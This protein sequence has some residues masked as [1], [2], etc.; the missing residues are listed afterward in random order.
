MGDVLLF[1][2]KAELTAEQNLAAF[3]QFCREELILFGKDLPFDGD[4]W[5]ITETYPVE[6]SRKRNRVIFSNYDAA[7]ARD[8]IPA[9]APQFIGF[10]KA[11]FRYSLSLRSSTTWANRIAALRVLEHALQAQGLNGMVSHATHETFARACGFIKDGYAAST[12][13]KI[14]G[15]LEEIGKLLVKMNFCQMTPWKNP[16]KRTQDEN[17]RV[18][19]LA[20]KARDDKLP[21]REVIEAVAHVFRSPNSPAERIVT[22]TVA[23]MYC[24]PQRINEVVRLPFD[25]EVDY[26]QENCPHYGLRVPGSK[27]FQDSVR[28][29]LPTMEKVA[30][31]AIS[32]LKDASKE[33]REVA[34][35][36]ET[37]PG[38]IYLLPECEYLRR[39]KFVDQVEVGLMLYGVPRP[40]KSFCANEKIKQAVKGFYLFTDIE[41][42][43]LAKLPSDLCDPRNEA[44]YS[45]S[46]FICRR[47]ELDETLT[48]Y[49]CI[50][51]RISSGEITARLTDSG[52]ANSI[53][54]RR[55]FLERDGT[56]M[57]MRSH[58]VRHYLNT[59]AQ[60]NGV[61]QLDIAM[62]SG[63]A[64]VSQNS[65]Y[66]HVTPAEI[67]NKTKE[68]AVAAG[69]QLFAGPTQIPKIRVVA[70]RD[71]ATGRLITGTAHATLYGMCRHDFAA[72]PCPIHRDCLNCHEHICVKGAQVKLTNIKR[73]HDETAGLLASAEEAERGS[74]HG[75]SRWVEH[76]KRTLEHC[77][78]LIA[79]LESSTIA[80]GALVA[81]NNV[82]SASKFEQVT[83]LRQEKLG[84]PRQNKLLER[85]RNGK[86]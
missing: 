22:S 76:H 40:M 42:A 5:D 67:L 75:A 73:M 58:Q 74:K 64:D 36:Y 54:K 63:R 11:Y 7:R 14:A 2:P 82:R 59:L 52:S 66:D 33:A 56:P 50:I 71:D 61:S 20:D 19:E 62:W 18:G 72:S 25:C 8:E 16:L 35:W 51:D 84:P 9:L 37:H 65:A 81:L 49:S 27:G 78:Q 68:I 80:D 39:K 15:Q 44:K 85:F 38:K 45:K 47:F 53:F 31:E 23:V 28:W 1:K 10:A 48:A 13:P 34:L 30:R 12:A 86:K 17:I 55:G 43:V 29:L 79:I 70:H 83:F 21:S 60:S 57:E 26:D 41:K 6:G 4:V 3:E 46:L 69:S 77:K 32:N 24:F